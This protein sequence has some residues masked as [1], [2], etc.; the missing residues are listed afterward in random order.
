MIGLPVVIKLEICPKLNIRHGK[1]LM[2]DMLVLMSTI[3]DSSVQA[4]DKA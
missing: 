3:E 4:I 1:V 2:A